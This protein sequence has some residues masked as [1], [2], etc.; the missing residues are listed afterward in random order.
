M[1]GVSWTMRRQKPSE[2]VRTAGN[3]RIECFDA[4]LR[5]RATTSKLDCY[6]KIGELSQGTYAIRAEC[7][8]T[9]QVRSEVTL[10]A[11][12]KVM[13]P[14]NPA[15]KPLYKGQIDTQA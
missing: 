7:V 2:E 3:N 15:E 9:N 5:P 13:V 14:R 1:F 12:T 8:R 10:I 4:A 6:C 11:C